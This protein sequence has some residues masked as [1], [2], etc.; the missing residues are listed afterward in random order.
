MNLQVTED[1]NTLGSGRHD[2]DFTSNSN[3]GWRELEQNG[4]K[5][6]VVAA[7]THEMITYN[8]GRTGSRWFYGVKFDHIHYFHYND[9]IQFKFEDESFDSNVYNA[10]VLDSG[11]AMMF[12]QHRLYHRETDINMFDVYFG[13]NGQTAPGVGKITGKV[14]LATTT[15]TFSSNA[16]KKKSTKNKNIFIQLLMYIF[17]AMGDTIQTALNMSGTDMSFSDSY[18]FTK[19][20]VD[21]QTNSLINDEIQVDNYDSSDDYN[22]TDKNEKHNTV[23]TIKVPTTIDNKFGQKENVF[24]QDTKIPVCPIDLYSSSVGK[25]NYFDTNFFDENSTNSSELW[26]AIRGLV[27]G[28]S[29]VVMYFSAGIILVLIIWRSVLLIVSTIR[30]DPEGAFDAKKIIDNVF[31]SLIWLGC[32]YV[33]LIAMIYLYNELV[34]IILGGKDSIYLIRANVE[35]VYSFNTNVVGY[36]RFLAES[37]NEYNALGAAFWYFIIELLNAFWYFIMFARMLIIAFLIIIAPIT[38]VYY[39]NKRGEDGVSS[40]SIFEMRGFMRSYIIVVFVPLIVVL[41]QRILMSLL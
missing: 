36:F 17:R 4:Q 22:S 13:T 10:I 20:R 7:A 5:Y 25:V 14:I 21:I 18:H 28:A 16:G 11:D 38:A 30:E 3:Y 9:T 35:D 24:T 39:M 29:H 41:A 23:K 19:S 26:K 12:P 37:N 6:V 1:G 33:L 15:G 40:G 34:N 32:I 27:V 8:K 2:S 31:K